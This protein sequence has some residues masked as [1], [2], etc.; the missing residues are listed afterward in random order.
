MGNGN[1]YSRVLSEDTKLGPFP[2]HR[3]KHVDKPTNIITEHVQRVAYPASTFSVTDPAAAQERRRRRGPLSA[4]TSD[5]IHHLATIKDN[6]V[7]ASKASIPQDPKILSRHIKQLGYFLKADMVGICHLPKYA[8][9][10][11]DSNGNP[12][13]IDYKYAIVIVMGWEYSAMKASSGNDSLAGPIASESYQHLAFV[14][15]TMARYIR[16]LGYPASA[17]HIHKQPVAYQVTMPPLLLWA[18]LGEVSRLGIILNPFLGA[19][20]KAAA[21]LTDLPLEPDKP[22]DFG[23]Q[24]FCQHCMKCAKECPS[25]AI[26][27]EDKV[28]YNGYETWKLN[29]ERCR[30]FL[31]SSKVA[32]LCCTCIKGCPWT[33]PQTWPHNFVRWAVRQSSLARRFAIGVDA[34]KGYPKVDKEEKWW[35]DF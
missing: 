15:Q 20:F 2:M 5:I 29:V 9:Y 16:G 19:A 35:F 34:I 25:R 8:I 30:K 13:D 24:D 21:V 26:S 18:G 7:A 27:T 22:I 23:L 14:T 12:I 28:I 33:R 31:L 4:S 11:H 10:T 17:E 32:D 6:E 3:L 1:N